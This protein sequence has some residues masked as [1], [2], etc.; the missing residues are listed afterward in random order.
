MW[1]ADAV[2]TWRTATSYDATK[3][4]ALA[5]QTNNTRAGIQDT[6]RQGKLTV[7]GANSQVQF[8]PSGDRLI[9]TALVKVKPQPDRGYYF[10]LLQKQ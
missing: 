10:E 1:G 5:I 4:I 3:A 6:L 2:L 7:A 9:T 8:L